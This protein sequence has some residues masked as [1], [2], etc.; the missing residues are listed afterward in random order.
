MDLSAKIE[1]LLFYRAEPLS[2]QE[3]SKL[4]GAGE[5]DVSNALTTLKEN[6]SHRGLELMEHGEEV[7]LRT[8]KGA[9]ELIEKIRKEE[10]ERDLGRA[11]AETL[12]I[13]LYQGPSTRS[14]IDYIRG[15][16]S[17]FILRHLLIRGLINRVQNPSDQRS[18]LYEPSL[19]LLAHLGVRNTSDLPEYG[20]IQQELKQFVESATTAE[21]EEPNDTE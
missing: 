7:E 11:G 4:C 10:R 12:A 18:F 5:S 1:A 21:H 8:S 6:L 2:R 16:N 20:E 3:L 9:S 17:T 14:R 19:E 15:V 13:I